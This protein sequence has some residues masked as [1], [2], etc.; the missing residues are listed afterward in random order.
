[1]SPAGVYSYH[2]SSGG[3][4]RSPAGLLLSVQTGTA[5]LRCTLNTQSKNTARATTVRDVTCVSVCVRACRIFQGRYSLSLLCQY[6]Q[7]SGYHGG[8]HARRHRED[9]VRRHHGRQS[10]T[11]CVHLFVESVC[12]ELCV[13]LLVRIQNMRMIDGKPEYKNGLVSF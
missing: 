10:S 6:D 13:F 4:E 1:M 11:R 8:L 7:R 12:D 3:G 5:G 2:G 9:Q